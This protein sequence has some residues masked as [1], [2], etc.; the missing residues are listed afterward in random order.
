[1][2][3]KMISFLSL[4]LVSL[5]I[6]AL[7]A[8]AEQLILTGKGT[9]L[10]KVKATLG[11]VY[12]VESV[13]NDS[14]RALLTRL[15]KGDFSAALMVNRTGGSPNPV[16]R[17]SDEVKARLHRSR[18]E[19][20]VEADQRVK[21]KSAPR[22]K[23]PLIG[24]VWGISNNEGV[25]KLYLDNFSSISVKGVK[26]EDVNLPDFSNEGRGTIVALLDSGFDTE[27]PDLM[28]QF[29]EKK[30]ECENL[31]KYQECL[32]VAD[33]KGDPKTVCNSF[34]KLDTDGNG[35]PMDCHGWNFI[36]KKSKI[37]NQYGD[38]IL[39]EVIPEKS[40]GHGTKVAGI[41]AAA[42]G[43]GIGVRGIAPQAKILGVKVTQE[44]PGSEAEGV[45][46]A[47]E[48][49]SL[50]S[51]VVRGM[52]YAIGEKA[53]IINLSLGWNGRAD[54]QLMRDA[55]KTAQDQGI[56]VVAAAANDSTDALVYPC[57]YE[58]VICVASHDPDGK[59]SEFSNFGSGVDI[60]A[61]GFSILSTCQRDQ[62]PFFY[63][64]GQGYDFDNGTSFAAPYTAG[65]LAVLRSQGL[66]TQEATARL[67]VGARKK[68]YSSGKVTLAGNL[69]VKGALTAKPRPYLVPLNKGVYP[70]IWDRKTNT[71]DLAIDLKNIW[72]SA[73]RVN[74]R[75]SLSVR[76]KNLGQLR[77]KKRA[78]T[79]QNWKSGDVNSLETQL[80][81]L[82]PKVTSDAT[83]VLQLSA[84]GNPLE[85]VRIQLQISVVL[86]KNTLLP[87]ALTLPVRGTVNPNGKVFTIQSLDGRPEQDYVSY[88]LSDET[89][90]IQI[91]REVRD[92]AGAYYLPGLI[93]EFPA[94]KDGS[95]R[96]SQRLD[97]N[98]DGKPDYIFSSYLPSEEGDKIP[99][100]RLDY[101]DENGN[102]VLP[103]YTF[104]N[105]TSV[106]TLD[107]FQ[108][109][110][111]GKR[112]VPIWAGA[113]LTPKAEKNT[114]F[115]PWNPTTDEDEDAEPR[116]YYHDSATEDGIRSIALPVH[117]ILT[118]NCAVL[119]LLNQSPSDRRNGKVSVLISETDNYVAEAF[120]GEMISPTEEMKIYP[121][122]AA[123]YRNLRSVEAPRTFTI[124]PGASDA[125]S[126]F[127]GNSGLNSQRVS[128]LI[129]AGDHYL[130]LDQKVSPAVSSETA[131]KT[132]ASFV[133][134][135]THSTAAFAQGN[136]DLLYAD[137][138]TDHLLTTSLRRYTYLPNALYELS[139]LGTVAESGGV[140]LPAIQIPDGFGAYPGAEII[141]PIRRNGVS[142]DLIRPAALRIQMGSEECDWLSKM[143]PTESNPAQAVYFC[144]D[145][146]IRVPYRF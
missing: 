74:A 4:F 58:G 39:M 46:S 99:Y 47:E 80:V 146:I 63:T 79:F 38:P 29:V 143:D 92:P 81:I 40:T 113:G 67:L 2:I 16:N 137:S 134:V 78:F 42:A 41:V 37:Y 110:R 26:G 57:Q 22:G 65:A 91:I 95:P 107:R 96:T 25:R 10:A 86:E 142:I 127:A 121:I 32:A 49:L 56:I 94:P 128:S 100:F 106:L 85:T 123:K 108:W 36:G 3:L 136:Y 62:D 13:F 101:R 69:D 125:A 17:F 93:K 43:N 140:R 88:E 82:D 72:S 115:D 70:V 89:W 27:H 119:G 122:E 129:R 35:Y 7:S 120:V 83:L 135:T 68:P 34:L 44:P 12:H 103:S 23:D 1:M 77:I 98:L 61:P 139:F 144:G 116:V 21:L 75:L 105:R 84:D 59:L 133:D 71:A 28:G 19:V 15:G 30:G 73:A 104:T 109:I 102:E 53:T 118:K 55:V 60:A 145:E 130:L 33:R 87:N 48:T 54:S 52:I 50:I 141:A 114:K 51:S 117:S 112:L 45:A 76:D 18:V 90:K 126:S 97:V 131:Y 24:E 14:E 11:K 31:A 5:A 138:T 132:I 64:D 66:S 124:N 111:S 9:E 8:Q 20:T 6:G